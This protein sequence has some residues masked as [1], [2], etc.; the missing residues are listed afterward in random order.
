MSI[1]DSNFEGE[2]DIISKL[3][4][5]N[6]REQEYFES[7]NIELEANKNQLKVVKEVFKELEKKFETVKKICEN[8]FSRITLKKKEKEEIKILLKVM[9]FNDEQIDLIIDKK[10]K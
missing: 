5:K 4:S 7:I 8:F 6:E 3:N 9:D 10:K 2:G 1:V